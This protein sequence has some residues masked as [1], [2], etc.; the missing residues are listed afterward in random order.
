M[1]PMRAVMLVR[2][3]RWAATIAALALI[4]AALLEWGLFHHS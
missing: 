2:V 4:L 1:I 3:L